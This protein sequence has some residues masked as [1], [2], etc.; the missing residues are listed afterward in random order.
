MILLQYIC[1]TPGDSNLD[2]S[3]TAL[4][5]PFMW[6][7]ICMSSKIAALYFI[8][9]QVRLEFSMHYKCFALAKPNQQIQLLAR[10]PWAQAPHQKWELPIPLTEEQTC[11]CQAGAA[12]HI[13]PS[14]SFHLPQ[15]QGS[16]AP[17][18]PCQ[19]SVCINPD[20]IYSKWSYGDTVR[21][22]DKIAGIL[23]WM[24][25]IVFHV[26]WVGIEGGMLSSVL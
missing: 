7:R 20:Y 19:N 10:S 12:G 17:I 22:T 21:S 5:S 2:R 25:A 9:N 11:W 3:N 15:L 24:D 16:P 6:S 26:L 18:S 8:S 4:Q 13:A 14:L 1:Q 23:H